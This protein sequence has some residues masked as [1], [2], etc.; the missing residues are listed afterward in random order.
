MHRSF[1]VTFIFGNLFDRHDGYLEYYNAIRKR[2]H[3]A[4]ILLILLEAFLSFFFS[5]AFNPYRNGCSVFLISLSSRMDCVMLELKYDV[6]TCISL[7][8]HPRMALFDFPMKL[9]SAFTSF[10]H[11]L[12]PG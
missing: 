10:A 1:I 9:M 5:H 11:R 7:L 2:Q 6:S 8:I 3:S 12:C 4:F